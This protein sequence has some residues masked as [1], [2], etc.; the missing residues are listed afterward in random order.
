MM[1]PPK[2][3]LRKAQE[4]YFLVGGLDI[5]KQSGNVALQLADAMAAL[6]IAAVAIVVA[7]IAVV[8]V[9]VERPLAGQLLAG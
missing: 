5:Q 9:A 4:G 8:V 3:E 2:A 6:A 1:E 7:A